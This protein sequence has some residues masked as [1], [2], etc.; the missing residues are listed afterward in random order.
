MR[1][2]ALI[3]LFLIIQSAC[4]SLRNSLQRIAVECGIDKD[5]V[6]NS[7]FVRLLAPN[8]TPYQSADVRS[9]RAVFINE[10]G[11]R[12]DLPMTPGACVILPG[13][14]GILQ[15]VDARNGDSTTQN[16]NLNSAQQASLTAFHLTSRQD[17]DMDLACPEEGLFASRTLKQPLFV[18]F[19]GD[20]AGL[21]FKLDAVTADNSTVRTLA[22]KP[23]GQKGLNLTNNLDVSLLSEG[24]YFLRMYGYHISEGLDAKPRPILP[25]KICRLH[26]V[27]GIVKIEGKDES[28]KLAVYPPQSPL[29]WSVQAPHEKLFFCREPHV[30]GR[31][32][33]PQACADRLG[34]QEVQVIK[35]GDAGIFDYYAYGESRA[36]LRSEITCQTII[37]SPRAPTISVGWDH[38]DLQKNGSILRKPYAILKAQMELSH[39]IVDRKALEKNLSCKVDFEVRGQL[40]TANHR[41][42][43]VE[44]RCAGQLLNDFVPC[45]THISMNIIEALNQPALL[46]SRLILTVKTDDGAGH[47]AEAQRSLWI[48][49]TAWELQNLSYSDPTTFQVQKIQ[50]YQIDA[51]HDVVALFDTPGPPARHFIAAYRNGAWVELLKAE[52]DCDCRFQLLKDRDGN[53]LVAYHKREGGQQQTRLFAYKNGQLESLAN[54]PTLPQPVSCQVLVGLSKAVYCGGAQLKDAYVWRDHEWQKLAPPSDHDASSVNW[55][56]TMDGHLLAWSSAAVYL[57]TESG[58]NRQNLLLPPNNQIELNL[59]EDFKGR[60]WISLTDAE[61]KLSPSFNRL[62]G[63]TLIPFPAPNALARSELLQRKQTADQTGLI[64]LTIGSQ[65]F[66][67]SRDLWTQLPL[68]VDSSATQGQLSDDSQDYIAFGKKGFLENK[69]EPLYWPNKALE[70]VCEPYCHGMQRDADIIYFLDDSNEGTLLIGFKPIRTASFN[71]RML[72]IQDTYTPGNW[73]EKESMQFLF[74]N[75]RGLSIYEDRVEYRTVPTVGLTLT[76]LPLPDGTFCVSDGEGLSR[77][78]SATDQ[79]KSL[80]MRALGRSQNCSGDRWGN[81]WW[82]DFK[83]NQVYRHNGTEPAPV[84]IV[85]LQGEPISETVVSVFAALDASRILVATSKRIVLLSPNMPQI[86]SFAAPQGSTIT[87]AYKAGESE[88]ILRLSDSNGVKTYMSLDLI[89]GQTA[90]DKFLN[91]HLGADDIGSMQFFGEKVYALSKTKNATVIMRSQG[92]WKVLAT[93]DDMRPFLIRGVTPPYQMAIDPFGRVWLHTQSPNNLIRLDPE[94]NPR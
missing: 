78:D 54:T 55:R 27:R 61:N 37:V 3:I 32:C 12:A 80:T 84:P 41:V 20:V 5:V 89:S 53:I 62:D 22:R 30:E 74:N 46:L 49:Q 91:D 73:I 45:D 51:S 81:I 94:W 6:G 38:Q 23:M 86:Q 14:P 59:F 16:L 56:V 87:R 58:W 39:E 11:D 75:G 29:P 88:V 64:R 48:N 2:P 72:N 57:W 79:Y 25:D 28:Q 17:L 34:F 90:E 21:D 92:V 66:D 24:T 83:E 18:T 82:S 36:G 50:S 31:S 15:V 35:T 60:L 1:L 85:N 42:R 52:K 70:K 26:I 10:Q 77:Y 76:M 7:S 4:G 19:S 43:C 67:F 71:S 69:A 65:T 68:N 13:E 44:G 33:Q 63:V 9:L 47:V 93:H 40:Q 8:G